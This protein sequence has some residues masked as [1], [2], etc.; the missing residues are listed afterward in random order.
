MFCSTNKLKQFRVYLDKVNLLFLFNCSPETWM[1]QDLATQGVV[2]RPAAPPHLWDDSPQ[3]PWDWN[4]SPGESPT[5]WHLRTALLSNFLWCLSVE[6]PWKHRLAPNFY[7]WKAARNSTLV[8]SYVAQWV[9]CNATI[10]YCRT[11]LCPRCSIPDPA[12]C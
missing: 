6:V 10:P 1:E 9:T 11:G 8:A 4:L 7:C 3:A 12:P 2:P 5:H